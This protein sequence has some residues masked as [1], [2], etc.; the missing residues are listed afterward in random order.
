M[1]KAVVGQLYFN[2]NNSNNSGENHKAKDGGACGGI[3]C[4]SCVKSAI[5]NEK[6]EANHRDKQL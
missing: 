3:A 1:A 4:E 2:I 6:K 5:P